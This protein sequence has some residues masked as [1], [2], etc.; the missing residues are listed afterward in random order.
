MHLSQSVLKKEVV[1]E[2]RRGAAK[3]EEKLEH[4]ERVALPWQAGEIACFAVAAGIDEDS[5]D[6]S[7]LIKSW[8]KELAADEQQAE[9]D[10]QQEQN[11]E[12]Q[13]KAAA[14]GGDVEYTSMDS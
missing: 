10:E 13:P 8:R 1:Q 3:L 5:A 11:A 4:G 6:A 14:Q 7:P 2:V 12:K 9:E